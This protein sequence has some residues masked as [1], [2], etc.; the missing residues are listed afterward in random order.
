VAH[1]RPVAHARGRTL[2]RASIVVHVKS[3]RRLHQYEHMVFVLIGPRRRTF[4]D[5]HEELLTG[6]GPTSE[7]RTLIR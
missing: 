1:R 4:I 6:I 3:G 7:R 2:Y 5:V